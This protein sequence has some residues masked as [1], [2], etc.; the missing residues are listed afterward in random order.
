MFTNYNVIEWKQNKDAITTQTKIGSWKIPF[1]YF[2]IIL[3]TFFKY[4]Y[5]IHSFLKFG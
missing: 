5:Y 1:P 3:F 2:K 4:Y